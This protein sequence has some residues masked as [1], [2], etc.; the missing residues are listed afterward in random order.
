MYELLIG[1][2]SPDRKTK[3]DNGSVD[4]YSVLDKTLF[5]GLCTMGALQEAGKCFH[6]EIQVNWGCFAWKAGKCELKRFFK[7]KGYSP[8][9]LDS[10]DDFKEYAVVY[11][12][13]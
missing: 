9:E 5:S 12:D 11:I 13:R 4:P 8:R 2:I 1:E 3:W 7:R 6:D 10:F